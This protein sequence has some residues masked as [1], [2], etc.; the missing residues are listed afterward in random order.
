MNEVNNLNNLTEDITMTAIR[1][2]QTRYNERYVTYRITDEQSTMTFT[3]REVG[4]PKLVNGE[5]ELVWTVA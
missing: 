2:Q 3:Q 4:I 1:T 5:V